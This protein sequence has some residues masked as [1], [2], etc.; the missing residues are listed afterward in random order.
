MIERRIFRVENLVEL[1]N[2]NGDD[3]L[4][5]INCRHVT[6]SKTIPSSFWGYFT[7]IAQHR[8]GVVLYEL[9]LVSLGMAMR[10]RADK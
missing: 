7:S 3:F 1:E 9:L 4:I 6:S 8:F 10:L 5:E 2:Q